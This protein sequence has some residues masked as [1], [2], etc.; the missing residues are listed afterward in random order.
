[1]T[2]RRS[3]PTDPP[4]ITMALAITGDNKRCIMCLSFLMA[5]Y[6]PSLS[7]LRYVMGRSFAMGYNP[8]MDYGGHHR[9][10]HRSLQWQHS[11]YC[12]VRVSPHSQ[13]KADHVPYL[14]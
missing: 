12:R 6:S 1:M 10:C 9:Q 7:G 14:H 11:L 5:I 2:M 8:A 13:R 4:P 3:K